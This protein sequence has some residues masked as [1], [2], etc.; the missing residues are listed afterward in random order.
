MSG[1]GSL[2]AQQR[3]CTVVPHIWMGVRAVRIRKTDRI[4]IR[5]RLTSW[6][7]RLARIALATGLVAAPLESVAWA[8]SSSVAQGGNSTGSSSNGTLTGFVTDM[9]V[10]RSVGRS[11]FSSTQPV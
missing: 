4:Q 6:S 10:I 2:P 11:S 3:D 5:R 8:Q 9:D 1:I 7:W